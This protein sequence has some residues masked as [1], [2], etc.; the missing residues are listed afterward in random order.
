[1]RLLSP[2]SAHDTRARRY[3]GTIEYYFFF[4][5][6]RIFFA[7][8]RSNGRRARS[9]YSF[10]RLTGHSAPAARAGCL[11]GLPQGG[12]DLF[13]VEPDHHLATH[14]DDGNRPASQASTGEL[15]LHF[16]RGLRLFLDVLLDVGNALSAKITRGV[17]AC[18]AP[19][20]PID[21]DDWARGRLR[22]LGALG[23]ALR[24]GVGGN[25]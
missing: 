17:V 19:L 12:V 11:Q 9:S 4:A 14:V 8:S 20:G 5:R 22:G 25:G 6:F 23:G 3:K 7:G 10:A 21:D 24:R 13:R 2:P 18:A 16:S 15:L 1:M